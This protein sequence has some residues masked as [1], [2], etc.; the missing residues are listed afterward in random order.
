M[1]PLMPRNAGKRTVVSSSFLLLLGVWIAGYAV[2]AESE[3]PL[4][5]DPASIAT[6]RERIDV[7]SMVLL[8]SEVRLPSDFDPAREYDLLATRE[9]VA[10]IRSGVVVDREAL[11]VAIR[12]SGE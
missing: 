12:S 4:A 1:V 2:H 5:P 6:K 3:D 8:P 11:S 7:A 10:V 9:I